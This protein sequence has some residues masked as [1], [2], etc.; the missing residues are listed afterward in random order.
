[1]IKVGL[2]GGIGSGKT[3]VCNVF[4][5]F[6]IPVYHADIQAKILS[7]TNFEIRDKLISLF[8]DD[9]YTG[10]G[11]DRKQ[12]A[13]IVFRNKELLQRINNII[14]PVVKQHF[15]IWMKEHY[16]D[17]YIIQE[18]AILFESG[19]Q[20]LFDK[21]ITVTAPEDLRIKR[22]MA[23]DNVTGEHVRNILAN[24]MDENEKAKKSDYVIINDDQNLV[25][26]QIMKIH[27]E[28]SSFKI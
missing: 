20:Q 16:S 24:Q 26:P 4:K 6:G 7:D 15:E 1:M 10:A 5:Y 11:L 22:V 2:T 14:H 13:T 18:A 3:V 12:L 25:L 28:L 17:V 21:I 23:R 19:Y 9:I 27:Q 8:G